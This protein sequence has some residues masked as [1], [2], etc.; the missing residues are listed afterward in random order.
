[1]HNTKHTINSQAMK[2]GHEERLTVLEKKLVQRLEV[3]R[4]YNKQK[5]DNQT[6]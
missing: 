5:K 6:F 4:D 2:I 1:M 3:N